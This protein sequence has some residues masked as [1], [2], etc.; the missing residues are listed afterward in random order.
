[1]VEL[2]LCTEERLQCTVAQLRCTNLC[3]MKYGDLGLWTRKPHRKTPAPMNGVP[4][5][6]TPSSLP[7]T[8]ILDGAALKGEAR[9]NLQLKNRSPLMIQIMW[10]LQLH[11]L[12][13]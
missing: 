12:R 4:I 6:L 9:G 8:T 2:L 13:S 7:I 10:L 1:M 3:P 11:R 5:H